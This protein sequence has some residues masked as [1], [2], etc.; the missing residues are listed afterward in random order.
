MNDAIKKELI[1]FLQKV[2]SG[3]DKGVDFLQGELPEYISQLLMWHG[4][5]SFLRFLIPFVCTL[6][7]LFIAYKGVKMKGRYF[8]KTDH[9]G[10]LPQLKFIVVTAST[11]LTAIFTMITINFFNLTWLKIWIAPKVFIVD[12]IASM[13]K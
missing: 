10:D 12:Y 3:V 4:V 9:D 11:V 1:D 5:H 8:G 7:L 6:I 13:G 2:N